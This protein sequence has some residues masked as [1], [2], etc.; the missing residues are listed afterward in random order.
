MNLIHRTV[1]IFPLPYFKRRFLS[2]VQLLYIND[3]LP[4]TNVI[5]VLENILRVNN[6]VGYNGLT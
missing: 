3:V 4:Y 1:P 6:E 5:S 2:T